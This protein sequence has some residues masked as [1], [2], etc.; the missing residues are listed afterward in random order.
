MNKTMKER[1]SMLQDVMTEVG[2]NVKFSEAQLITKKPQLTEMIQSTLQKGL[3]GLVLKDLK[4]FYEPGKRHW[5]KVK[6]DYLNEGAMADSADLVVL[7]AWFG[8]GKRGSIMSIFLMGCYDGKSQWRTVTKVHTGHDDETLDRLQG[9]LGPNMKKIKGNYDSVPS[10]LD[11]TR[12]MV[13]DF[14]AKD[15]KTSP[16]WEITGAEFSKAEIHTADG[17][18]IRFPRVTKIRDDKTWET[19]TS[20]SEL[21]KLFEESKNSTNLLQIEQMTPTKKEKDS[22]PESKKRPIPTPEKSEPSPLKKA[23]MEVVVNTDQDLQV[24]LGPSGKSYDKISIVS[25]TS[26]FQIH[27]IEGDLFQEKTASLAHCV[28]RDMKL[29]KGIA[30]TFREKFGRIQELVDAKADI[31]EIAVLK[32]N[33]RF[34]YNLVTK[35]KYSDK[36]TY[37]SLRQSLVAMK[38]HA[39]EHQVEAISMPKIGCGL[40]GLDWNAVRTLIKNVFLDTSIELKVYCFGNGKA[41]TSTDLTPSSQPKNSVNDKSADKYPLLD[42]AEGTLTPIAKSSKGKTSTVVKESPLK[43]KNLPD[44]FSDDVIF[45]QKGMKSY[46]TMERYIIAYGGQVVDEDHFSQATLVVRASNVSEKKPLVNKFGLLS[47]RKAPEVSE[48]WLQESI[49]KKSRQPIEKYQI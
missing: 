15:P 29:G 7:G 6:K 37:E 48:T 9:Q 33:K 24:K 2:N 41:S 38:D 8:S 35:A 11:C 44:V 26:G 40:D 49:S 32:V 19:A 39:I 34:I 28:S 10:W 23:R 20:L 43:L 22:S 1:R 36:P 16:V 25:K 17:I 42:I 5:L 3:E 18:S 21:K 12:Q 31:G 27:V 13:P 4:G 45:L 30:K 14:V 46:E 47:K